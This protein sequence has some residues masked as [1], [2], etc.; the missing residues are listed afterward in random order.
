MSVISAVFFTVVLIGIVINYFI[1]LVKD[2]RKG[3][4]E[5]LNK[6]S[7]VEMVPLE[8]KIKEY[9]FDKLPLNVKQQ[10]SFR[11]FRY[12]KFGNNL[13][14]YYSP[15][16][17]VI[18]NREKLS[19]DKKH[20]NYLV[21][22]SGVSTVI[23]HEQIRQFTKVP[24][25]TLL[26][27]LERD[28]VECSAAIGAY[29][30][31][32]PDVP[33]GVN[34]PP[35]LS[36]L[37]IGTLL[38]LDIVDSL[39]ARDKAYV[40]GFIETQNSQRKYDYEFA[41]EKYNKALSETESALKV[42]R[43]HWRSASKAWDK[44]CAAD[45]AELSALKEKVLSE[46]SVEQVAKLA[47]SCAKFPSWFPSDV[48]VSFDAEG[49]ILIVEHRLPYLD[50]IEWVKQVV[51]KNSRP[52]KPLTVTERK[53]VS[54]E[55]YPL[56]TLSLAVLLAKHFDPEDVALIAVNG[57][58]DFRSKATGLEKRAFCS[59]LAASTAKLRTIDLEHADPLTAYQT[60]KGV[61]TPSLELAPVAPQLRLDMDD[62]RFV[63]ARDILEGMN[64]DENLASMD[65]ED[66]EHLCRELFEKVFASEGATV[67]VTQASRDQ[68]VDAII[69]DPD[70]IR[71]GK[72]VIQAKRYVNTVDVSAVRDLW[73]VVSHE[74]AMKGL[75]VTTS[76]FGPD[77]YAF[78]QGKPLTLIN[79]SEL[80]HLLEKNGYA[81]R[82]NLEEARQIQ[83][84]SG[85]P[86]FRK[87]GSP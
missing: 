30:V 40:E 25:F 79:G 10:N 20:V 87:R 48:N 67:S 75:L 66:F 18:R 23:N 9:N 49:R 4:Q 39:S 13:F 61:T 51:L 78:A 71:G 76:Q 73:G 28:I 34:P 43:T 56:L 16:P 54:A 2:V 45:A 33:T 64:P 82:I 24:N 58:V 5:G 84:E 32:E 74:G 44:D 37:S 72:I 68:G 22:I 63:A 69:L 11:E 47:L 35:E 27:R 6:D 81:F 41:T 15:R 86:P 26:G 7:N 29:P 14:K 1:N 36:L 80:L 77:S 57:W 50:E 70:P 21:R 85:M 42:Q 31:A 38:T 60:L 46:Y 65:W 53:K 52:F 19:W 12:E 59:S 8:E 83:R 3:Y 62:K 55:F 17:S